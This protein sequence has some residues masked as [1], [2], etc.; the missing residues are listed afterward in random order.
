MTPSISSPPGA[1]HPALELRPLSGLAEFQAA[2]ALQEQTWGSGFAERVPV[3]ILKVA[4]HTGGVASGAFAEDGSLVGFVFGITGVRDGRL[5]H[6]SDMLAVHPDWRGSGIGRAL[7]WH[8]R[9]RLRASGID[10]MFWTADPLEGRNAHLNLNVLGARAVEYRVDF[11]GSS[12]SPLHG[13][14]PTDRL[15]MRWQWQTSDAPSDEGGG[16]RPRAPF[17]WADLP[18]LL[19]VDDRSDVPAPLPGSPS[20]MR[21]APGVRIAI[22]D[23]IGTLMAQHRPTALRWRHAVRAVLHPLLES[24]RAHVTGI[25]RE[26]V[27][28]ERSIH[29]LIIEPVPGFESGS[30][31]GPSEQSSTPPA[32]DLPKAPLHSRD[33][34]TP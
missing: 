31:S 24:G 34:T 15:V 20:G 5:I 9:E 11:Y 23:A 25:H 21:P 33:S 1:G 8:Q 12:D 17:D 13:G 7:K 27:A 19:D 28:P 26:Y 3:S 6:W 14:L 2:V 4:Q 32:A 22:P 18:I 29:W 10:T 30:D 16:P